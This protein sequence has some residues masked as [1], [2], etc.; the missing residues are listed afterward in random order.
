MK[1][2]LNDIIIIMNIKFYIYEEKETK[3]L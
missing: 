2:T 1:I 3:C